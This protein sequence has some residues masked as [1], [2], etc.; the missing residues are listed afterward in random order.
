M[1]KDVGVIVVTELNFEVKSDLR[2]RSRDESDSRNRM[3][4]STLVLF[5]VQFPAY[6]RTIFMFLFSQLRISVL[7][8]VEATAWPPTE[9]LSCCV[10]VN[11]SALLF[12]T[13]SWSSP[14][15]RPPNRAIP[16]TIRT[17]PSH[18]RTEGYSPKR[19]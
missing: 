8:G 2:G 3:R 6:L 18:H 17:V 13:L 14:S 10:M 16:A 7:P 15:P 11:Q 12:F 4:G 1:H 5:F 19:K 9:T